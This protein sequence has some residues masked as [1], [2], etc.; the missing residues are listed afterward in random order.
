MRF[1]SQWWHHQSFLV[2]DNFERHD[3]C[4]YDEETSARTL[5]NG[6]SRPGNW[7]PTP[8]C[9]RFSSVRP[10]SIN[11]WDSE[12]CLV[13]QHLN[14]SSPIF[15][16]VAFFPKSTDDLRNFWHS[17]EN[18]IVETHDAML[19]IDCFFRQLLG[20]SSSLRLY[21]LKRSTAIL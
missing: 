1:N 5:W 7:G 20:R 3:Y 16:L 13:A 18:N 11:K 19:S 10:E 15:W 9:S 8:E 17:D 21:L 6:W 14:S 2:D 12:Y 4:W